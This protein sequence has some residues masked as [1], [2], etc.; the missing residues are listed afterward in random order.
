MKEMLRE[1]VEQELARADV[2]V[3]DFDECI[4]DLMDIYINGLQS[5][6]YCLYT[7][8]ELEDAWLEMNDEEIRIVDVK[9][10]DR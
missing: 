3:L 8:D 9:S 7:P 1:E 5:K 4:D 10:E 2:D 6:P